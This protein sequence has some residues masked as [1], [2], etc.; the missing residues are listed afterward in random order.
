M[1]Q[2][3]AGYDGQAYAISAVTSALAAATAGE[4]LQFRWVDATN[5][6][7]I[8]ILAVT[9]S[10][11]VGATAF[12]AGPVTFS[13]S[14]ARAWTG[15]GTGGTALTLT[16]NEAKLRTT[17]NTNLVGAAGEIRVATTAALGAGTK[18]LAT[19]PTASILGGAGAAAST[20]IPPGSALWQDFV[21]PYGQPIVL[22]HQEGLSIACTAL[23]ATGSAQAA[24]NIFWA[25]AD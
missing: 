21:T 15:A 2:Q 17:E 12:T 19:N 25:E 9:M 20:I 16:G 23:P 14:I 7:R 5:L 18:T 6:R 11:I 3:F 8:R 24:F 1:A 10:A 22:A 4:I 13:M